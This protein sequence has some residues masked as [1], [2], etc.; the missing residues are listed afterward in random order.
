MPTPCMRLAV[1]SDNMSVEDMTILVE[2]QILDTL[3]AV[4]GVADVQAYGDREKIFRVDIDQAKLASLG[5]TIAD[6]RNALSSVAFDTP[7]GALTTNNQNIIVRATADV[8]TPEAFEALIIGDENR[9]G[10]VATVT[11]GPDIAHSS[12]RSDGKTGIGLGIIRQAQSNTLDISD[13]VRA[14][15]ANIQETLPE[16]MNI[17]VT[18]DDAIFV[19][20]A[21]HEVEI[22]LM[23]VG[24]DRAARSSTC[25]CSTCAPR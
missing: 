6:I 8:T 12:L 7:A 23:L 3:S 16:G 20:G 4:P 17:R 24:V 11:L 22:A 5:L 18:S 13:G 1:T 15:V 9:L 19:E 14:A 10:D 25:S 21:M 2:D